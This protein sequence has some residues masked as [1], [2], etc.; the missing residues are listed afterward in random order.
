M[1]E[2]CLAMLEQIAVL[3]GC[4]RRQM[5]WRNVVRRMEERWPRL[6]GV[7]AILRDCFGGSHPAAAL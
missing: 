5:I 2:K 3:N 1:R 6:T 4:V 7:S